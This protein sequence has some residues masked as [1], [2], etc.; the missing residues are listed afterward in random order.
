MKITALTSGESSPAG[1]FRI[2]QH[3]AALAARGIEVEDHYPAIN[4]LA[5]LPGRLGRIRT[6]YLPPIVVGQMALN[7][8]TRIP[9]ILSTWKTD[10][11][12]IERS[13]IPGLEHLVR[14]TKGPR[15]L[16]VDDAIWMMNPMGESSAAYLARSM[17][18]VIAG[19]DFLADWYGRHCRNVHIVP[20][21]VDC[22]RYLP[23]PAEVNNGFVIGWTGTSGNFPYFK[24]IEKPLARFLAD[25]DDASLLIVADCEPTFDLIPPSRV[26][27]IPWT[28][29]NEA[30]ILH[31]MTVGIMPLADTPWARGKCSFKML[32]YM[33]SALPVVVSPVGMNADVL[34]KGEMGFGAISPDDWYDALQAIYEHRDTAAVMGAAGRRIVEENY[35]ANIV[36]AL[37]T[38]IFKEENKDASICA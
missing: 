9:G 10:A 14:L 28:P 34:K 31:R 3:L 13:F 29:D 1:R 22:K 18:V 17:D 5:R 21:A 33:A 32:Q 7:A 27:F 12:W 38:D 19:N 24:L 25:H 30:Q 6:R 2:R 11:L 37:L 8:A 36:S 4:Q 23:K 20:T 35:D 26:V 15:I 16:D